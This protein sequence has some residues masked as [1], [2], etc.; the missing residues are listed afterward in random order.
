VVHG[1]VCTLYL[2]LPQIVQPK[3]V[4]PNIVFVWGVCGMGTVRHKARKVMGLRP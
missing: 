2:R 1:C 4:E 3:I